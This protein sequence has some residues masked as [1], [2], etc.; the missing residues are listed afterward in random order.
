M[1][2]IVRDR[3]MQYRV[4]QGQTLQID[5]I[6]AEPGSTI[7]F[8]EVLLIGGDEH[9]QVG[10][11]LIEGAKVQVQVIGSVKGK[12]IMILRFRNKKRFRRRMGHRQRYTKITVQ[13]I[14]SSP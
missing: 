11:P 1:Y 13:D 5:L 10:T 7:E 8:D 6:E 14:I 9:V 4:E 2:A 12:K 3:G